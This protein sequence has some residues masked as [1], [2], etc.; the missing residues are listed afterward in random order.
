MATAIV[1][2]V[3][4]EA[5]VEGSVIGILINSGVVLEIFWSGFILL[6][7]FG[8]EERGLMQG[9]LKSGV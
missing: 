8:V 7:I 1:G 3:A 2:S 9:E 6:I 5:E 4:G